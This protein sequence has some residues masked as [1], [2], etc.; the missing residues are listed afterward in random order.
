MQ[1]RRIVAAVTL[2][3]MV[4]SLSTSA[5][6]S[7]VFEPTQPWMKQVSVALGSNWA[8][9]AEGPDLMNSRSIDQISAIWGGPVGE[10]ITVTAVFGDHPTRKENADAWDDLNQ[11]F[12]DALPSSA[13]EHADPTS[14]N[15]AGAPGT[16]DELRMARFPTMP[17]YGATTSLNRT[18][19]LCSLS[20]DTAV[21]ID[22][23]SIEIP[24]V[25]LPAEF[26]T[27]LAV[28]QAL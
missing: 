4:T 1:I 17:G 28:F 22:L 15:V 19:V 9:V 8:F 26:N 11:I 21:L 7:T 24:S 5:L 13:V 6:A 20:A 10:R 3:F 25:R 27:V 23:E 2:T 18:L 16:C 14:T 12:D